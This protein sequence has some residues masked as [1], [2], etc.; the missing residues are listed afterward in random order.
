MISDRNG[1]QIVRPV[2]LRRFDIDL[3]IRMKPHGGIATSRRLFFARI[4]VASRL[5]WTRRSPKGRSTRGNGD[6][7]KILS[8]LHVS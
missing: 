3:R 6:R 1:K 2:L 7:F 8:G 5:P 4:G